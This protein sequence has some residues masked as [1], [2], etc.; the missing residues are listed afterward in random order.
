M[1]GAGVVD[2]QAAGVWR[3]KWQ[4]ER[5]C[6]AAAAIVT[7]L[8]PATDAAATI[9]CTLACAGERDPASLTLAAPPCFT[10]SFGLLA[11][12]PAMKGPPF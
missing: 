4:A 3:A 5:L 1:E 9:C 6:A 8:Q 2:G 11:A 10:A 7:A 12:T